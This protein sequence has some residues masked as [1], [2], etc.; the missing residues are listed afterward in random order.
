M[1]DFDLRHQPADRLRPP[2]R[3]QPLRWWE[4]ML[5]AG[6]WIIAGKLTLGGARMLGRSGLGMPSAVFPVIRA[7]GR[8]SHIG[9]RVWRHQKGKWR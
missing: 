9:F 4:L 1:S 8:L 6:I 3:R 5:P 7:S 2:R